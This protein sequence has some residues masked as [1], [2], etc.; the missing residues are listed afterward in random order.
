MSNDK[1]ARRGSGLE[2]CPY[3]AVNLIETNTG[4]RFRSYVLGVMS[5]ARLP[6]RHAGFCWSSC[7]GY[8][9][10]AMNL[11]ETD[12]GGRFRSYVLPVMSG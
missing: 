11:I 8:L 1:T 4:S 10:Q 2:L 7:L 9:Y 6:L 5:P 3:Q 12:A